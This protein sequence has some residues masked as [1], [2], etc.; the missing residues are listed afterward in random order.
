MAE[1]VI[2]ET[3]KQSAKVTISI[4]LW[5]AEEIRV[6]ELSFV[7]HQGR[8]HVAGSSYMQSE[9]SAWALLFALERFLLEYLDEPEDE[10]GKDEQLRARDNLVYALDLYS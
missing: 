6:A 9:P 7:S 8:G 3:W 4:H 2:R 1:G 5:N 10:D